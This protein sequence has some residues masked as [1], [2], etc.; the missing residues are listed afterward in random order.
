MAVRTR[1]IASGRGEEAQAA[2]T[3]DRRRKGGKPF[4]DAG[5]ASADG[6]SP[7]GGPVAGAFVSAATPAGSFPRRRPFDPTPRQASARWTGEYAMPSAYEGRS[8]REPGKRPEMRRKRDLDKWRARSGGS[9]ASICRASSERNGRSGR[10]AQAPLSSR[11]RAAISRQTCL[12]RLVSA[13][14]PGG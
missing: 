12:R 1:P 14:E 9:D 5:G 13:S 8:A 11:R 10:L 4:L 6:R 7:R 3:P 2:H